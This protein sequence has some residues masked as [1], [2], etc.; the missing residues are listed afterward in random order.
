MCMVC[1]GQK[2]LYW[3]G[4]YIDNLTASWTIKNWK[5]CLFLLTRKKSLKLWKT[6]HWLISYH[7]QPNCWSNTSQKSTK[8]TTRVGQLFQLVAALLNTSLNTCSH[9]QHTSKTAP[10]P[11]TWLRITKIQTSNWSICSP[12]M[13]HP[14]IHAFLTWMGWRHYTLQYFLNSH[15][16]LHPP[17]DTD[18]P[19]WACPEQEHVFF[20]RWG[21][22]TNEW[23]SDG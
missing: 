11:S 23:R 22:L 5:S 16:T 10:M 4:I 1:V 21:F 17:T 12:W 13:S 3:R 18:L 7:W 8:S 6:L 19:C 9:Y 20:Q 2:P 14:C 15:T